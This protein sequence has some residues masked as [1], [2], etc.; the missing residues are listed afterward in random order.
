MRQ[1]KRGALLIVEWTPGKWWVVK[2]TGQDGSMTPLHEG[3]GVGATKAERARRRKL[4]CE[5][6]ADDNQTEAL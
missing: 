1:E 3:I 5:R 4:D 6:W 2:V